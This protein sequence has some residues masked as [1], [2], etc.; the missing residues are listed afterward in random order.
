M[1]SDLKRLGRK[2]KDPIWRLTH[3]YWIKDAFGNAI[4]FVPKPEQ[5]EIIEAIYKRGLRN[6]LIPKARQ[7]GM[8][9]VIALI[10]LDMMVFGAGVQAALV[11]QTQADASK[12]LKGKMVFAFDRL[13]AALRNR[14]V[15]LK[16][17]DHTFSIKLDG[18]DDDTASEVQAGMNARGDTFQILHVSEWGPIAFKDPPR[19]EEIMTGAMPAAKVGIR[20]VE[21]TWKGGKV[22][23]LWDITKRALEIPPEYR[24]IEDFTVFFFPWWGDADYTLAGDIRQIPADCAK[25]LAETEAEI[26]KEKGKPFAFTPGQKLWYFKRAWILGLFRFQEYPSMLSECFR[27][28]VEGAIYGALLDKVRARGGMGGIEPDPSAL[29]NTSWDLGSPINTVVWYFQIIADEIRVIDCDVDL[30]LTPS[31]RVRHMRDKGYLFGWHYLPHDAEAKK[32]KGRTFQAELEEAGLGNTRVVPRTEDV[33]IGINRVRRM[34]PRMNFRTPHC[35]E[36]INRL[37][38]YRSGVWIDQGRAM[39]LPVHDKSSHAADAMRML[40]EADLAGMLEA[41]WVKSAFSK[42]VLAAL[43]GNAKAPST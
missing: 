5:M 35:E 11:D 9:T 4:R 31:E 37:E 27:A 43:A 40:A 30:D 36:G 7:L 16:S 23:H 2:L 13:P 21:T 10:M 33:W 22:G 39:D 32:D 25:Y 34:L 29:V 18:K 38:S 20:I 1:K 41:G 24:T 17:N 6:L 3:L 19:S 15:K 26:S 8:S 42:E 14:F 12:K 28:P